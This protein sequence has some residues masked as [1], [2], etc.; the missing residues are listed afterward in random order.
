MKI[1]LVGSGNVGENLAMAIDKT[2]HEIIQVI[3]KSGHS[4]EELSMK[5]NCSSGN[6]LSLIDKNADLY[7]ISVND[8]N[9]VDII[10]KIPAEKSIVVHTA[11][12]MDIKILD[13]FMNYGVLY[14]LQTFSKGQNI[15]FKNIPLCI[16]ANNKETEEILLNFANHLSDKVYKINTEQRMF[17]HLSAVFACNFSNHMYSIAEDILNKAGLDREFLIPLIEQTALKIKKNPANE[18][19]TGPAKRKDKNIIKKHLN[20]L[21]YSPKLQEIYEVLS[22]SIQEHKGISE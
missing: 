22:N 19:Q 8:E 13:R 1:V 10:N 21:S 15:S 12:S 18:S 2:R 3:S 17:L 14:P 20:L 5:I 11:G 7:I 4:S 9:L 16:E 6:S